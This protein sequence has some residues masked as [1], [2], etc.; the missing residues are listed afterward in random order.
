MAFLLLIITLSAANAEIVSYVQDRSGVAYLPNHNE[1]FS[2]EYVSLWGW[3]DEQYKGYG[4]HKESGTYKNGKKDGVW[5]EWFIDGQKKSVISYNDGVENGKWVKWYAN[6]QKWIE[7]SFDNGRADGLASSWYEDGAKKFE[8]LFSG[9]QKQEE[10]KLWYPSGAPAGQEWEAL[11]SLGLSGMPVGMSE[12]GQT[13]EKRITGTIGFAYRDKMRLRLNALTIYPKTIAEKHRIGGRVV[14][15]FVLN[16]AGELMETEII[17]SS[18]HAELD[19]AVKQMIQ[20][21]QPFEPFPEGGPD[22]VAFAFPVT[23]KTIRR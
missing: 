18:G 9:G 17:D 22:K 7:A 1:P 12:L 8:I 6:G 19:N 11:R 4:Q 2:G 16:R 21:A 13:K 5:T 3:G 15:R 23:I 14:V 20:M 10:I